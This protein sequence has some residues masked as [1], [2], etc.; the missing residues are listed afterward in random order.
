MSSPPQN[1]T[2]QSHRW[3]LAAILLGVVLGGLVGASYG[4]TMWLAAGKARP[5]APGEGEVLLRATGTAAGTGAEALA[6]ASL[7]ARRHAV[8]R[9]I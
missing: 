6:R 5:L 4:R 2:G 3:G 9:P 8:A 1:T 7:S